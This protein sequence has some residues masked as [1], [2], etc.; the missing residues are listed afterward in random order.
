MYRFILKELCTKKN[1]Y[2]PIDKLKEALEKNDMQGACEIVQN[3]FEE[4]P[5]DVYNHKKERH[6]EAFYHGV[7]HILFH[8]LG[9]YIQSEVHTSRGR[10]DAVVFTNTHI[11]IF[12]FKIGKSTAAAMQQLVERKYAAKFRESG[13]E[14]ALIAVNFD[15]EEQEME[16]WEVANYK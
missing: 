14:V 16:D 5:Y 12:E 6:I 1:K 9:L 4:L 10:A 11:F 2:A 13:K 7:I 3:V 15:K 8:Y